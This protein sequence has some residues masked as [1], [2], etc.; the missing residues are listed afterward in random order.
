MFKTVHE[1]SERWITEGKSYKAKLNDWLDTV[2]I[3]KTQPETE[4]PE[5]TRKDMGEYVKEQIVAHN[6]SGQYELLRQLFPPDNDPMN[7][8]GVTECVRQAVMLSDNRVIVTVGDWQG[9]RVYVINNN[10]ISLQDNIFMF[11]KSADKKYFAKVFNDKITITEGWDGAVVKTFHA[12]KNYGPA[13]N[14]KHPHIKDGL[15]KLGLAEFGIEQVVVF[16]S[17]GSIALASAKGIF[18]IDEKGARLIQIEE[19]DKIPNEEDFTFNYHYPHIDVSPDEKYIIVG[20]QSSSHLLLEEINGVWTTVATVEPRSSYPNLAMFN[21]KVKDQD[22]ENDGPQ[23][24]L[25]SCH[26]GGGASLSLPI[27]NVTP[28]FFASGYDADDTL[29]YADTKKWVFSAGIND[30]G[31]VL[32]CND[33][34]IW[35]KGYNGWQHGYLYVGGTVM[36]IDYSDDRTKLIVASYSGQVIIYDCG[37][38]MFAGPRILRNAKNRHEKRPDDMAIT[39]SCYVDVKRYLFWKGQDPMIW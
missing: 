25:C 9:K 4:C 8:E 5:E 38:S 16:P 20:Y 39:N 32:G 23:V 12:P 33:G 26:L 7:W 36:D 21:Y 30:W 31:Y 15:G 19:D 1:A 17:G 29:N 34:Y 22:V 2:Y 37:A 13:F 27:K 18:I 6:A 28:G 10:D 3:D 35:F 11:G 24:L 14:E